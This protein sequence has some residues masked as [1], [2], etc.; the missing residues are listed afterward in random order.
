MQVMQLENVGNVG[1]DVESVGNFEEN[2][3]NL[4]IN[5]TN[6]N[7]KPNNCPTVPMIAQLAMDLNQFVRVQ[8]PVWVSGYPDLQ[9]VW[10]CAIAS[11]LKV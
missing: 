4:G 11:T 5:T 9:P 2:F 6:N 8:N 7:L 1:V 10:S 3:D